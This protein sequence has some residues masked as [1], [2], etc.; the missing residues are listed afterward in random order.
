MLVNITSKGQTITSIK[1]KTTKKTLKK[2]KPQITENS[3]ETLSE[4]REKTLKNAR[5]EGIYTA[6]KTS[7]VSNY[8]SALGIHLGFSAL[9]IILLTAIPQLLGAI[10]QLFVEKTAQLTRN[11]FKVL[12]WSA[13]LEAYVW[14]PIALIAAFS[15]D[16][17]YLLITLVTL[18]SIFMNMQSPIW[19]AILGDVI[20]S[21]TIAK[22]FGKRNLYTGL[23]SLI[24]TILGGLII[25][26]VTELNI[27]L[28]FTL[29]FLL[30]F[31]FARLA[32]HHQKKIHDP[33]PKSM[34]SD[35]YSFYQFL[36]NAKKNNF[37]NFAAFFAL[38]KLAVAIASPFFVIYMLREL[39]FSFTIYAIIITTT[40]LSSILSTNFWTKLT[41]NRGA[42][43]ALKISSLTIPLI[44]LLWIFTTNWKILAVF[45]IISGIM[46]AG[47]NIAASTFI[48]EAV[49]QKQKI[50][51]MAYNNVLAGIGVFIGTMLG[52]LITNLNI[53]FL[54]SVFFMI[55]LI[56]GISRLLIALLMLRKIQ[57][58]KVVSI[59]LKKEETY[60]R[61][62]TIR[63]KEGIIFEVI[64]KTKKEKTTQKNKQKQNTE[65]KRILNEPSN[66]PFKKR[67][68]Y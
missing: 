29:L 26:R 66:S 12:M 57:E 53:K 24:S 31:F 30:G 6:A 14:I 65:K 2:E 35:K 44:P 61:F 37:G 56:S 23:S 1:V 8:I 9:A 38:Y 60:K 15:I 54:G 13:Y 5:K 39:N 10:A 50:K 47:F 21:N 48:F 34:K 19:N 4:K 16:K 68:K 20:P 3:D 55:F 18:D 51:F 67:P 36:K 59:N 49:N 62:I 7:L 52:L 63:P 22:Y 64:G 41:F 58:E 33:S 11:R 42:R 45:E 27:A 25:S 40:V 28:G 32:A 17:P 43:L 46:W